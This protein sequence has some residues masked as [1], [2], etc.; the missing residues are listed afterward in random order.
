MKYGVI[1]LVAGLSA[2]APAVAQAPASVGTKVS[3]GV[4]M[5]YTETTEKTFDVSV[6][7]TNYKRILKGDCVLEAAGVMP[8]GLA[9]PTAAE[10]KAMS[11]PSDGMADLER[12]VQKCGSDQACLMKLMQ[13]AA[14]DP[15]KMTATGGGQYQIWHPVSCAGD[16]K[17]DDVF[18][19]KDYEP[20]KGWVE[21]TETVKGE[22]KFPPIDRDGWEAARFEHNLKTNTTAYWFAG[23]EPVTLPR[24]VV[25]QSGGNETGTKR[26]TVTDGTIP[27]P[28]HSIPGAPKGGKAIKK[29]GEGTLTIDWTITKKP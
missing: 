27:T 5:T 20:A 21:S 2:A 25:R 23:A 3:V 16:F 26:V 24:D 19:R 9:G 28:F 13:K 10:E 29:V 17:V 4:T 15:P 18:W 6:R 22:A 14:Q 7:R 1:V 8:Y 12:E 11:E